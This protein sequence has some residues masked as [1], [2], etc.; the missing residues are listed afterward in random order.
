MDSHALCPASRS[1]Q[2]VRVQSHEQVIRGL[3]HA[4]THMFLRRDSDVHDSFALLCSEAKSYDTIAAMAFGSQP[5]PSAP[6]DSASSGGSATGSCHQLP[7]VFSFHG[8][9]AIG[10]RI[11]PF[12]YFRFKHTMTY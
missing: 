8:G 6:S 7:P 1:G 11:A 2:G 5:A 10:T 4:I 9:F 12:P 3:F